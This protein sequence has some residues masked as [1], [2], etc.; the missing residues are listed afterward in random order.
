MRRNERS[1]QRWTLALT[2]VGAM[3]VALDGTVVAT[4]L[5]RIRVDLGASIEQLEWTVNAYALSFAVLLMTGAALGDRF[6]RRRLYAVGLSL[7]TVSSALCALAP[8]IN[9]LIAAR[10]LQGC[11]AALVMPLAMS[12]LSAAFPPERR[13]RALGLFS[14][15]MGVA[16]VAG[17]LAGGLVT[18]DLAWQW[19]FWLNVPIG[20]VG[21]PLVLR[22]LPESRGP[23]GT[24]DVT[25]LALVTLGAF[26][27]VWGLVTANSAGWG[28]A[29]VDVALAGGAA[30]ILLF[31]RWELRAKQPMVPMAL[32]RS[33]GFSAGN[34]GAVFLYASL[35][36]ALF[37][38]SQFLQ[39]G[40]GDRPLTAGLHMLA[41]T[42]GVTVVAPIAGAWTNR[43][44]P[45]R[46][47]VTGLAL[48]AA[49]MLWIALIARTD[50]PFP[51]LIAP[52][53]MAGCGVSMAMPA[54]QISVI[55]AVQPMQI[56]KAS[57]VFNTLR[58]FGGVLGVAILAPVFTATG[59]YATPHTFTTGFTAAMAVCAAL[60]LA[61]SI[62]FLAIPPTRRAA[63]PAPATEPMSASDAILELELAPTGSVKER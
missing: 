54:A 38:I 28:S 3:M 7:F 56:G 43:I 4:A 18:Q 40:R 12:L 50:L 48:Q 35:Y 53:I 17:P 22:Q 29:R 31:V 45:R 24:V 57:G 21:V 14:G 30:S 34:G 62:A 8:S 33:R 39:T 6:G 15:L 25:G 41:W 20:V 2:S 59:S 46:L 58:Q 37:F 60:S 19:I 1:I 44:G 51:Q 27:L 61:G 23:S 63:P 5:N 32:F 13:A 47:A 16:V 36:G 11:G 26:G 10:T 52:M 9:W 42:A 49:G 55:N